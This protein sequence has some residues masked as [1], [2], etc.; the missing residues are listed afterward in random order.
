MRFLADAMPGTLAKWLRLLGYD[1]AYMNDSPDAALVARARSEDRVI[2][3]RDHGLARHRG[4][5]TLLITEEELGAQLA[6]VLTAFHLSVAGMGSRCPVCN[7]PLR[8]LSLTEAA[9]RVPPYVVAHHTEFNECPVCG[10]VYWRGTHW[11]KMRAR[12]KEMGIEQGGR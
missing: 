11:E 10:R 9:K 12:L 2:L 8:P 3:T 6:Q 4:V 5:Q 7:E 1:T